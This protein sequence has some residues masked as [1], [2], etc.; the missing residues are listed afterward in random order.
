MMD[1]VVPMV[2]PDDR[3]WLSDLRGTY[4]EYNNNV[5][6]RSWGTEHTLIR[7]VRKNM[8]FVGNIIILL[9]RESQVQPWMEDDGI[10]IVFHR[11]F[12]PK[13]YLPTYNSRTIEM[14][15]HK[16]DGL[17]EDF[18]YGNDDMFPL[19]PLDESD[20]FIDGVPCI[21]M[22]EKEYPESPNNFQ[23]ACMNGLNFV[24]SEFGLT[25]TDK[26]YK[27][28]HS[29]APIK[30]ST[31][32]HLW[33]IGKKRIE[34]SIT[35]FR[36]PCNFNQYIYSWWQFFSGEYVDK[37]PMRKY[38]SVKDAVN[39]VVDAVNHTNG[40]ICINDNE[41]EKDY[42]SYAIPVKKA[43]KKIANEER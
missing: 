29:I 27:N 32:R 37:K 18:L 24:A 11:D 3:L 21:H 34:Q 36:K 2:F 14:F 38:V 23:R 28:G 8:K 7:L 31:C 26:W 35:P 16:I 4:G 25:F 22:T 1:Y 33:E 39:D 41:K 19:S 30:L 6:W 42:L 20:F 5:R 17:S 10:R 40:I 15:L 13:R 43:L 9:A 12:I